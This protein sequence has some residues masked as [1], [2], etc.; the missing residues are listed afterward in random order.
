MSPLPRAPDANPL[1]YILAG[2]VIVVVMFGGLV[3]WASV[4]S[5]SGAV[6]APG[7][8]T[9]Y[10]KRRTVQ[11]YDGGIVAELLVRDGDYV[12]REQL[13]IRLD[14]TQ[15]RA[16]L[17]VIDGQLNVLRIRAARLRS[18]RDGLE[19]IAIE[20]ALSGRAEDPNTAEILDGETQLFAARRDSLRGE[21]DILTERTEQ[22]REQIG[23]LE[24]QLE[25][26]AQQIK[27]LAEEI[28]DLSALYKKGHASK[29]R[30]LALQRTAE[31]LRGEQGEHVADIARARSS[32]GEAYLQIIQVRKDFQQA[33]VSELH[34]VQ[35]EI[36]DLEERRVAAADAL[37]RIDIRAP[38]AGT[39]VGMEMHTVGGVI[40]PGQAILDIVP[41]G[42][43][44]VVETMVAPQDIDKIAEGL[45]AVIRLSAFNMRTTPELDGTVF[46]ASA[47]RLIDDASG[48]PYFLVSVRIATNELAKLEDLEVLP[49][50]PAEV[51]INTGERTALSFL[52][53]PLTDSLARA[54]NED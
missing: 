49:G 39:V 22:L 6:V 40:R 24:A 30:L 53:K 52:I 27:L 25:S 5:L 18:E 50:M 37:R 34:Q 15:T 23:G 7:V 12:E 8:M 41:K 20:R 44:L 32:I 43:E 26:K 16:N 48:Q 45:T 3:A 42:D 38:K 54:F 36:F 10:S 51:F 14:A 33:V 9:V 13:L 21:E 19:K 4:A 1:P 28:A 35:A 31:Q 2:L 46:T 11:H 29:P 47:D 17:A